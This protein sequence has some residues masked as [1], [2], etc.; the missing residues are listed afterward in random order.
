M[1]D[2]Q[3]FINYDNEYRGKSQETSINEWGKHKIKI[4]VFDLD[5]TKLLDTKQKQSKKKHKA[6][7]K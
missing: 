4:K 1:L 3:P 6:T 7:K 5:D 2:R